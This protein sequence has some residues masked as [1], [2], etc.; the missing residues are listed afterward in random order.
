MSYKRLTLIKKADKCSCKGYNL[1]KLL[2]PNILALLVTREMH[3]YVVIQEL[4][5]LDLFWGEKIDNTG[6]YRTL[7]HLE[8]KGLVQSRWDVEDF[9]AAKKIYRI[10]DAGK[11]CLS[12]WIQSLEAYKV[13]IDTVIDSARNALNHV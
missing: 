4:M 12:N 5:K 13:I 9:G 11:E 8:E 1:D 3:G 2:Q 6:I 10:N 7:N